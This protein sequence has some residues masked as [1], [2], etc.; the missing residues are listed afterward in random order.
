MVLRTCDACEC[1]AIV[2][3]PRRENSITNALIYPSCIVMIRFSVFMRTTWK[4]MNDKRYFLNIW[5]QRRTNPFKNIFYFH[6]YLSS[7]YC[8]LMTFKTL[9]DYVLIIKKKHN[10]CLFKSVE[11]Q[12]N[13]MLY[14]TCIRLF[15]VRR[16]MKLIKMFP[17]S[18]E[19]KIKTIEI[20]FRLHVE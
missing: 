8:E 19:V 1:I 6:F 5:Q 7:S 9:L 18:D 10:F 17:I 20:R 14:I 13:S 16:I 2:S 3:V 12:S 15:D 4:K 11:Q